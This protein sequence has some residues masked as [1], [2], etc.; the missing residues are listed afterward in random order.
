MTGELSTGRARAHEKGRPKGG[1]NGFRF[2][3]RELVASLPLALCERPEGE[4]PSHR[5]DLHATA[6]VRAI[7]LPWGLTLR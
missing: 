7:R 6:C 1:P 5:T 3:G 2:E 4:G